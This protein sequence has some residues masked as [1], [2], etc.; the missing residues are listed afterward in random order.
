VTSIFLITPFIMNFSQ[1]SEENYDIELSKV[2]FKLYKMV[3]PKELKKINQE[4]ESLIIQLSESHVLIDS[5]KFENTMLFDIIDTLENK[6][7]EYED[8]LKKIL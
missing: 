6:L 8:L 1:L 5:L 3:S 7:K 2:F 4:K